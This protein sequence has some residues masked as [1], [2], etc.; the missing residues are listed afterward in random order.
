MD[1]ERAREYMKLRLDSFAKTM[2]VIRTMVDSAIKDAA[3]LG[4]SSVTVNMP[5]SVFGHEPYNLAKMGEGIAKELF[6]DGFDVSGTYARMTISW[7]DQETTLAKKK[8]KPAVATTTAPSKKV[9]INVPKVTL[10]GHTTPH[11]R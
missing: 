1:A 7:G 8:K 3:R 4:N 11:R 10:Q 2:R 9:V 6:Q 5:G